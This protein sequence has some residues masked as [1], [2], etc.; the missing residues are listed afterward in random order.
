M[1]GYKSKGKEGK[2]VSVRKEGK[3]NFAQNYKK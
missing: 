3:W 2:K 1:Y